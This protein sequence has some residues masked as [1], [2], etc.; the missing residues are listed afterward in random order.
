DTDIRVNFSEFMN[1][2]SVQSQSFWNIS[3]SSSGNTTGS[4][5]YTYDGTSS[6]VV[7]QAVFTPQTPF[8]NGETVAVDL[9]AASIIDISDNPVFSASTSFS[10]DIES[11]GADVASVDLSV[12]ADKVI[13]DTV[14]TATL[15]ANVLKEDGTPVENLTIVN[16]NVTG[17][18]TISGQT[19]TNAGIATAVVSSGTIGLASFTADVDTGVTVI[20]SPSVDVLFYREPKQLMLTSDSLV[21]NGDGIDT[22]TITALLVDEVGNDVADGLF[23]NF[24]TSAGALSSQK[25]ATAGGEAV[26]T[27]TSL[28]ALD[29]TVFVTA[30]Y[31]DDDTVRS[32]VQLAFSPGPAHVQYMNISSTPIAVPADGVSNALLTAYVRDIGGNPVKDGLNVTLRVD[33]PK[34]G[35]F[36]SGTGTSAPILTNGGKA[37]AIFNVSTTVGVPEFYA[38]IGLTNYS[39]TSLE[40]TELPTFINISASPISIAADGLDESTLTVDMED[41]WGN[42]IPDGFSIEIETTGG[43][44]KNSFTNVSGVQLLTAAINQAGCGGVAGRACV[45][46]KSTTSNGSGDITARWIDNRTDP[47]TVLS[48][49]VTVQFQSGAAQNITLSSDWIQAVAN[50]SE[51]VLIRGYVTDQDG[52]GVADGS[53]VQFSNASS[54]AFPFVNI[55]TADDTDIA[56]TSGGWAEVFINATTVGTLTL[57]AEN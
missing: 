29:P 43:T 13:A 39:S 33:D 15:T 37:S 12:S 31:E 53:Q 48:D 49:V 50:G 56:L 23:V 40:I 22:A 17:T 21:I 7:S 36:P 11:L 38:Q 55:S 46:L 32:S 47:A 27:I 52:N 8:D 34:F 24:S 30:W 1:V 54:I 45:T 14:A 51:N 20:S 16:F 42:P 57:L 19:T 28:P 44:L 4:I 10:F 35:K 25:A 26:I 5:V 9:L 6:P 41:F 2:S 3:G 18:A